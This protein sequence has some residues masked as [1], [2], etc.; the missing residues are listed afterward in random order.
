MRFLI[1]SCNTGEGHNSCARAIREIWADRGDVCDVA[2][3]LEFISSG[4]SHFI[5]GWHVRIYRYMP[6]VFRCGY[7]FSEKHPPAFTEKSFV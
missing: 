2:D 1:L 7:G 5:S 4:V 6:E 3:A